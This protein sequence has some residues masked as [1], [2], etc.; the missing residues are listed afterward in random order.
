MILTVV[1]IILRN[2]SDYFVPGAFELVY[3]TVCI[4]V[5]ASVAYANDKKGHVVIDFVY[6]KF[7][8]KGKWVVSIFSS[9]VLLGISAVVTWQ[10][11]LFLLRQQAA[12]D[13]SSWF[14][15]PMWTLAALGTIAMFLHCL[16]VIADLIWIIKD[17]GVLGD[18]SN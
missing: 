10:I 9:L 17:K 14:Q 4:I 18:V 8:R 7:S 11:Y 12:N 16:S 1:D 6:E 2:V 13:I 5:F 3:I 15:I